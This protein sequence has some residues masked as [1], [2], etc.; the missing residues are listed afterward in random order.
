MKKI[1]K[2]LAVC[3]SIFCPKYSY[4]Q[5]II[6]TYDE[7]GERISHRIITQEPQLLVNP[8]GKVVFAIPGQDTIQVTNGGVED[9]NWSASTEETWITIEE[10][11]SGTND[12]EIV[13][14]YLENTGAE[15]KGIITIDG[16]EALNSPFTFEVTQLPPNN[17]P[18][19]INPL[20]DITKTESFVDT[21]FSI[22]AVFEDPDGDELSY[23]VSSADESVVTAS[24]TGTTLQLSK[25]A[26]ATSTIT[27]TADDGRGGTAS[28]EF[29]LYIAR[30][31]NNPPVLVNPIEDQ[32][33]YVGKAFEFKIPVNTFSD[34]DAGDVLTYS[35]ILNN[36]SALPEWLYFDSDMKTFSG[37]PTESAS[38]IIKATVTDVAGANASD[39]F[40]ITVEGGN[41]IEELAGNKLSVYPIPAKDFIRIEFEKIAINN[42]IAEISDSRG[43]IIK[44]SEIEVGKS[45]F[46]LDVS[47]LSEGSYFLQLRDSKTDE[48]TVKKILISK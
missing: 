18:V 17:P 47:G 45:Y 38:L 28:D 16:G 27:V 8:A 1:L 13:F 42:I 21:S 15:R 9:L 26:T 5:T 48:A 43:V 7:T 24:L 25:V 29:L 20:A 40:V 11:S 23:T 14:S 35:A 41:S 3:I 31:G 10:G 22:A 36:N 34:P 30:E 46:R 12:G 2:I 37:V 33:A 32:I 6:Y 4:S 44:S 19:V 39:L